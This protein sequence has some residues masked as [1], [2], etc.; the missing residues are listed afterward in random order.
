MSVFP[1]EVLLE[2]GDEEGIGGGRGDTGATTA[3]KEFGK[4]ARDVVL[5]GWCVV[6]L[7][8]IE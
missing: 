4:W 7:N 5:S 6:E 8:V 3:A 2:E 1:L